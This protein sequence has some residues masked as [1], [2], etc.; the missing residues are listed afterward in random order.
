MA[1]GYLGDGY[2]MNGERDPD[3]GRDDDRGGNWRGEHRGEW[4]GGDR[5]RERDRDR[6]RDRQSEWRGQRSSWTDRDR[7]QDR[8]FM[9]DRNQS[10]DWQQRDRNRNWD[11]DQ[12]RGQEHGRHG[13]QGFFSRTADEARDWFRDDEHDYRPGGQSAG[14]NRQWGHQPTGQDRFA[15]SSQDDHYRS[16]RQ[17]QMDA[18]DRD[19]QDYCRERQ[20][21]FH[22]DFSSWRSNRQPTGGSQQQQQQSGQQSPE[23]ELTAQHEMDGTAGMNTDPRNAPQSTIDPDSAATLGTNNSEN[24]TT[25]RGRR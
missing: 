7:D 17:Q 19:Y 20:Q 2:G 18:L 9:F 15:G 21:Q 5:D 23:L 10:S 14:Q 11:R 6:D 12:S 4:R 22:Q 16:W 1:H 25:G 13:G 3:G 24:S 8:G